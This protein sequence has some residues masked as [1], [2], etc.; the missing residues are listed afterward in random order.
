MTVWAPPRLPVLCF[1]TECWS[2]RGPIISNW[3]P[4]KDSGRLR[5]TLSLLNLASSDHSPDGHTENADDG[6]G[7]NVSTIYCLNTCKNPSILV[8]LCILTDLCFVLMNERQ[9][10]SSC[11]CVL[12]SHQKNFIQDVFNFYTTEPGSGVLWQQIWMGTW[13]W[14]HYSK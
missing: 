11:F 14:R 9:C 13:W 1:A 10:Q 4:Y 6:G 7:I 2:D 5:L 3:D 12:L 8:C